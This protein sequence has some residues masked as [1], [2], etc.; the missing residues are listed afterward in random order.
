MTAILHND[1]GRDCGNP[2]LTQCVQCL[3]W[4]ER[5]EEEL[6]NKENHEDETFER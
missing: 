6:S 4:V 2:T 3:V 1:G 5:R